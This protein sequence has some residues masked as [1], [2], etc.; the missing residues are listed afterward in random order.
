M[1]SPENNSDIAEALHNAQKLLAQPEQEPVAWMW[2]DIEEGGHG[3]YAD[4]YRIYGVSREKPVRL[5][6]DKIRPLYTSPPKRKP[7][8]DGEI[9]LIYDDTEDSVS[10]ARAIEKAHGI[11]K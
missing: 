3:E 5:T 1:S 8:S 7:L 6:I 11:G 4:K 10:F 9:C 2:E